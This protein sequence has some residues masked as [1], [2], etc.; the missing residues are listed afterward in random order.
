[1]HTS[2]EAFSG[3]LC[4]VGPSSSLSPAGSLGTGSWSFFASDGSYI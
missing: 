2:T 1:M 3:I 4:S